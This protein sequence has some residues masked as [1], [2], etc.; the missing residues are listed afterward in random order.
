M[1]RR[2]P[3]H[4][5][6]RS[7]SQ[8]FNMLEV[9]V[10]ILIVM[11][12]LLGLA[13]L[14]ARAQVSEV[15]SYQRAQALVLL[16]DMVDKINNNR[17]TAPCFAVTTNTTTGA[18]FLGTTGGSHASAP[19][20]GLSTTG[21]NTLANNAINEWDSLLQGANT[22]SGGTSVGAMIGARG[23][24]SYN[25]ATEYIDYSSGANIAG[26]GEYTVSVSWQGLT[27]TFTP[28]IACGAGL[29]GGND[30][31]RRTVWATLRIGTLIAN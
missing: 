8:G 4:S 22:T 2:F 3:M 14:Q 5:S 29:Y 26:T 12:G 10:A 6:R 19:G 21:N 20:C 7:R 15:E 16:Y 18:P 30:A 24:V 27:E 28:T 1:R 23:C 13:G 9:L 17:L 11:V 25:S 31:K